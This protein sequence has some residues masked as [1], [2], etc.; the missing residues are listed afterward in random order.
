MPS[1]V[2]DFDHECSALPLPPSPAMIATSTESI[3]YPVNGYEKTFPRGAWEREDEGQLSK[4]HRF[5]SVDQD[6]HPP[7]ALEGRPGSRSAPRHHDLQ[8][9]AAG[10][11]GVVERRDVLAVSLPG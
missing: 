11:G 4:Q 10:L 5:C 7:R 1:I 2:R 9:V 8:V 6:R 3:R